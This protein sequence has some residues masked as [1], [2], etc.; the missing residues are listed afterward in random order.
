MSVHH[1]DLS[2]GINT[3]PAQG[4]LSVL[5]SGYGKPLPNHRMGPAVHNYY[6][7]HTV[8]SGYGVF[9][10]AG[11][12]YDCRAG[13]TFVIVPGELFTYIADDK[14]PW[15]YQW[16]SFVGESAS[17][18]L[19]ALGISVQQP[20]LHHADAR[21]IRVLYDRIRQALQTIPSP[22]LADLEAG[23]LLR[24]L[25]RQ[26]GSAPADFHPTAGPRQSDME[27]Q[28]GQMAMWLSLQYDQDLSIARIAKTLG[29]H[30]THLS[31]MFKQVTGYS[32]SQYLYRVR[33]HRAESLLASDLTIGQVASSVG[34]PDPLYFSKQF[35]RWKGVTP[36][37]FRKQLIA[38]ANANQ[39][40]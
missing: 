5:F 11:K 9:E 21:R 6:L 25:L 12:R 37:T 28:V 19:E 22:V 36:S 39:K 15:V 8:K 1:Y 17:S 10:I 20:V 31:K 34:F 27:R 18:L 23:G 3:H 26:L 13:D 38:E 24:L 30:R 32:P 4:D 7:I 33:M 2:Q 16:V 29:Y 40:A 35:R 14:N